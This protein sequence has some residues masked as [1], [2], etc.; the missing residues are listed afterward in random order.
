M[1]KIVFALSMATSAILFNSCEEI[2][3]DF[4]RVVEVDTR[5]EEF[6]FDPTPNNPKRNILIEDFTG[7]LCANCPAAAEKAKEL[8]KANDGQVI[9]IGIHGEGTFT[10]TT[11]GLPGFTYDFTTPEGT[12]M[13][14]FF[15]ASAKGLPVGMISRR[16]LDNSKL[17]GS[18]KWPAA[19]EAVKNLDAIAY[20]DVHA[21]YQE[22]DDEIICIDTKVDVLGG[23]DADLIV[24]STVLEDSIVGYQING[25]EGPISDYVHMHVMRSAPLGAFGT[26]IG[27]APYT[28]NDE[29]TQRVSIQKG[30]DWVAKNLKVISY[31]YNKETYEI[32]QVAENHVEIE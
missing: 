32:L 16:D 8:E 6:D 4:Y 27:T 20:V 29:F 2:E 5:C 22:D 30:A 14:A 3:G 11:S 23:Y 19:V 7:H 25:S 15:G 1:K 13:D 18:S 28:S 21:R 9:V 10:S 26:P 31:I 24:V 12:E 17:L